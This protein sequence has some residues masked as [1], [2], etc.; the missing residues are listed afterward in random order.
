MSP[1]SNQLCYTSFCRIFLIFLSL[2]LDLNFKLKLQSVVFIERSA[3]DDILYGLSSSN[4]PISLPKMVTMETVLS[5]WSLEPSIS[6]E[7]CECMLLLQCS[8]IRCM[9][10]SNIKWFYLL[11][12]FPINRTVIQSSRGSISSNRNYHINGNNSVTLFSETSQF[13]GE[14]QNYVIDTDP[15][16]APHAWNLLKV[17]YT[18]SPWPVLRPGILNQN[19]PLAACSMSSPP[20]IPTVFTAR[21]YL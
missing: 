21:E 18:V 13:H 6:T 15:R 5:P 7:D 3:V 16:D 11:Q 1:T 10:D 14:I 9:W 2:V 4:Q 20:I 19:N 17:C 8:L 12:I